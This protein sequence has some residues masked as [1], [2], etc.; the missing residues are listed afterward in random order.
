MGLQ[1]VEITKTV[2]SP[3][4]LDEINLLGLMDVFKPCTYNEADI[5]KS[6]QR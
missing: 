1:E 2:T 5:E 6:T 3:A 4:A